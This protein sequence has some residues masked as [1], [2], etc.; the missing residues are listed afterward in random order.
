ME[1]SCAALEWPLALR[2]AERLV[3]MRKGSAVGTGEWIAMDWIGVGSLS[4]H[5]PQSVQTGTTQ[6]HPAVLPPQ[7]CKESFN[8]SRAF[9]ESQLRSLLG[10]AS[11]EA[12][13]FAGKSAA[14]QS[15]LMACDVVLAMIF[16]HHVHTLSAE[17]IRAMHY[18]GNLAASAVFNLIAVCAF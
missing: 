11:L 3:D 4:D 15:S 10:L 13:E 1:C 5:R 9:S 7:L 17:L 6:E 12:E 18:G 16:G 8:F 14:E 2:A